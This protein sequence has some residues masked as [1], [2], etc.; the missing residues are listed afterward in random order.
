MKSHGIAI[1]FD[2]QQDQKMML[3]K[4][5][6][7]GEELVTKLLPVVCLKPEK[8][9]SK[10]SLLQMLS[11]MVLVRFLSPGRIDRHATI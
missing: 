3:Y 8:M 11:F 5:C 9:W 4:I 10:G 6:M 7:H 1:C 2:V